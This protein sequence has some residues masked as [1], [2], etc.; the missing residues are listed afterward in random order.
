MSRRRHPPRKARGV[1]IVTAIFLLVVL[2]GLGVAMLT[3]STAQQ[4]ASSM[5]E[6]GVRAYQA[7]RAGL[8]WR[9]FQLQTAPCTAGAVDSFRLP[10]G[11]A[12]AQFTVT[13]TC[14][15]TPSPALSSAVPLLRHRITAVACNQ[16]LGGACPNQNANPD[17][18]QRRLEAEF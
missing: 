17:Y 16:P 4:A 12:L 8:E 2:A 15:P 10:D 9:F 1:S 18:V 14:A 6:Q 13:V 5:D 11:G 7:A 3:V